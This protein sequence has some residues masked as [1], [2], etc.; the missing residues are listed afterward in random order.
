MKKKYLLP[1]VSGCDT[2]FE[3]FIK[4]AIE[5][6]YA[7]LNL[8]T[9]HNNDTVLLNYANEQT[10]TSMFVNG[11]IRKDGDNK[12]VTAIQEYKIYFEDE[13][14]HGRPD[15]FI[16]SG[17]AAIWVESK[18]DTDTW[19]GE[20]HWNVGS[21]LEWDMKIFRQVQ[22][23]YSQESRTINNTYKEHYIMTLA[24][25]LNSNNRDEFFKTVE[26]ELL[27]SKEKQFDRGWYYSVGF[28]ENPD[29]QSKF[30]GVEMY[31]TYKKMK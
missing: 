29:T 18:F 21:W 27:P 12:S 4:N 10:L 22:R 20:D 19:I 6:F 16:R 13:L 31:G 26:H 17:E 28:I 7:E 11:L 15:I 8:Y 5:Q 2:N 1:V 23:Y 9:T 24:F 30:L 25:K 3:I 14:K